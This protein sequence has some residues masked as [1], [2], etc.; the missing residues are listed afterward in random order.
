MIIEK[1]IFTATWNKKKEWKVQLINEFNM[2]Y[3]KYQTV[4]TWAGWGQKMIITA[5]VCAYIYSLSVTYIC[6]RSFF[7]SWIF[8]YHIRMLEIKFG[9]SDLYMSSNNK[10][11]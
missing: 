3:N 4:I 7:Y 8:F 1:S 10:I 9:F 6:I 2:L 11:L 5:G